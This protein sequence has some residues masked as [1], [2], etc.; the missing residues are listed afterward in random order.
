MLVAVASAGVAATVAKITVPGEK[1]Y[2]YWLSYA[3]AQGQTET[4]EPIRFRGPDETVD[5]GLALARAKETKLYVLDPAS[6][7]EAV[8]VL[9][10]KPDKPAEVKLTAGS[11][12]VVRQVRVRVVNSKG[13]LL[14]SA[15][16]VLTDADGDRQ[17]QM[18]DP[19]TE[20]TATFRDVPSGA[21]S[22]K[23][24]YAEGRT[25]LQDIEIPLERDEPVFVAE[26]PVAGEVA[27][28]KT[29]S[30][31]PGAAGAR[32]EPEAERKPAV[33]GLGAAIAALIGLM[34]LAG[35]VALIYV[36]LK[37]KGITARGALETLG[38]ELPGGA[39][40]PSATPPAPKPLVDEGACPF[41]GQKKDP[42]TGACACTIVPAAPAGTGP[43]LVGV[44][45]A[46][47]GKVFEV[48][49][50][51]ITIG[52]GADNTVA[53]VDD[54]TAS[55]H[56]ATISGQAGAYVIRDQGSSNGTFVNGA[57]VAEQTL[58]PGDEVQIGS[59]RFRFE[60]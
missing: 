46:Y 18:V 9:A 10:Y 35:V 21:A 17:S 8:S 44:Q 41:C 49:D 2:I 26:V 52:R 22:V 32:G 36:M 12:K 20:G 37:A 53:L 55:R 4:T 50:T 14:E 29:P 56:H 59:T 43:R 45:G 33:S 47:M 15:K 48:S 3:D 34:I 42:V 30:P 54:S 25:T 58:K 60:A 23:V 6:G 27:T 13:K 51:G 5:D 1:A 11:F 24:M 28:L 31:K 39:A 19:T 16:L 57:K 40:Q 38:A 7:N